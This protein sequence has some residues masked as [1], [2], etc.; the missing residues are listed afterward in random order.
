IFVDHVQ[1]YRKGG[2]MWDVIR[3]M[4]G[5]GLVVSE[6]S[7]WLRQRR[8][9]QP[10]FHRQR[11]AALSELMVSAIQEALDTWEPFTSHETFN[12]S[13]ALNQLTMRVV[14]RTLFGTGLDEAEMEKVT[15]A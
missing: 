1:N 7:F 15:D 12:M 14:A 8:M 5:N 2:A 9:M 10:Q 4:L 3:A 13:P 11:I 6:G